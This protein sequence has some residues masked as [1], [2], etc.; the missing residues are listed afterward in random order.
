[1]KWSTERRQNWPKIIDNSLIRE[2]LLAELRGVEQGGALQ[3]ILRK[4]SHLRK[5]DVLVSESRES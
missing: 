5:V 2:A 1:M 4:R 3:G